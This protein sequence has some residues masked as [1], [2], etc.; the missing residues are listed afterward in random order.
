MHGV[1]SAPIGGFV[2]GYYPGLRRGGSGSATRPFRPAGIAARNGGKAAATDG[3]LGQG[4]EEGLLLLELLDEWEEGWILGG[5]GIGGMGR[6]VTR[7][8]M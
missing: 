2:L 8:L 3:P 1:I 7:L 5:E 4:L 6:M